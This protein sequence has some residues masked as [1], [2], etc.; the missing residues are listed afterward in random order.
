[1]KRQAGFTLIEVLTSVALITIVMAAT[2]STLTT[3]VNTAQGITMM[4]DTQ[5]NLRAGMNY[6]SRDLIQAGE[7]IPQNGLTIPNNGTTSVV[8]RPGPNAA[9]TFP[10]SWTAL[11]A[12]I[13]GYQLGPTT[14]TSGN[15]TDTV[16]ILYADS[17]LVNN[18]SAT[19]TNWLNKYPINSASCPGGSITTAG[20]T[21]TIV[22]DTNCV[23]ISTGNTALHVGDLIMLQNNNT[24]SNNMSVSA[25]NTSGTDSNGHDALL[26]VSSVNLAGNSIQFLSGD[27]FN[28]NASGQSTGTITGIQSAANTYGNPV[29]A[30][31]IWMITYYL[32]NSNTQLPQLMRQVNFNAA[33]PVGEV[34]ENLQLFYDILNPGS[35]PPALLSPTEQENPTAANLPYVRDSY[36]LL[37]ARSD[38]TFALSGKYIRNNL[39][40]AVSMRGLDYYNEFQ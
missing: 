34:I 33:Q 31:R 5:E 9:A 36:I 8:N 7:G 29:T 28:L 10:T 13:P 40:N 14:T 27:P 25:T 17:T 30:T 38:A 37:C 1:M 22:F 32:D 11:P 4:A 21:T 26:Y 24:T 20:S 19:S 18:V 2:L 6:I 16:T 12:V 3:A 35:S 23:N 15:P 39:I